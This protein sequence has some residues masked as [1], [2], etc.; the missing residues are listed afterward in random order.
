MWSQCRWVR[1]MLAFERPPF[2][3]GRDLTEP[4]ARVE[5]EGG[6]GRARGRG[7]LVERECDARCVAAVVDELGPGSRS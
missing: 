3:E 1:R 2:Q 7:V 6:H 4:G 5:Q